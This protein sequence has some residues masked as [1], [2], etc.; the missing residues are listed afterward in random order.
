MGLI[1]YELHRGLSAMSFNN[2]NQYGWMGLFILML[3]YCRSFFWDWSDFLERVLLVSCQEHIN[4][5]QY[6]E[7]QEKEEGLEVR[8]VPAL[9]WM[10]SLLHL[11]S[12]ENSS[13]LLEWEARERVPNYVG[14]KGTAFK[15]IIWF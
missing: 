1:S 3:L 9:N 5:S 2:L 6:P 7:N 15:L 11:P 4:Y 13:H 10:Y 12:R 14:R 8:T